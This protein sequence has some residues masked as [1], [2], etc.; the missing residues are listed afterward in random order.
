MRAQIR[1][2]V[3]YAQ[4]ADKRVRSVMRT[5]G[6]DEA[7]QRRELLIMRVNPILK[8]LH[9]QQCNR[10]QHVATMQHVATCC[11]KV[12]REDEQPSRRGRSERSS[13]GRALHTAQ[14][15]ATTYNKLQHW[16]Y[17]TVK[18]YL[19]SCG[20]LNPHRQTN[21]PALSNPARPAHSCDR[22]ATAAVSCEHCVRMQ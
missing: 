15:V 10:L 14:H 12:I 19:Y 7:S 9:L 20:Q 2:G 21:R 11:N 5:R 13:A 4:D 8:Q 17:P 1:G 3:E 18:A 16:L 22:T 6:E